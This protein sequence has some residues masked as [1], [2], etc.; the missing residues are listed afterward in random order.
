MTTLTLKSHSKN[1]HDVNSAAKH[2]RPTGG[3]DYLI[4]GAG[5]AGCV[6]AERLASQIDC[7]ILLIDRR[8]HVGG[9]AYDC[10]PAEGVM[11]STDVSV[12]KQCASLE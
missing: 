8:D 1:N 2:H 10:V 11:G 3:Y 7:R 5:F 6:L 9:N 12:S 4:V